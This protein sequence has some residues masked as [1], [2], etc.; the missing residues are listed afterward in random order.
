MRAP[1][2]RVMG[3]VKRRV[4]V[5]SNRAANVIVHRLGLRWFRGGELL[6]LTTVERSSGQERTTPVLYLRDGADWIVVASNGGA[7]REPGWWLNLQAGSPGKV[8]VNGTTTPVTG[9]EIEDPERARVYQRLL[10]E[11]FDY[12]TYQAKVSRRLAVVRLSPVQV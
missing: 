11:V 10:S 4:F 6:M 5:L 3:P 2:L 1:T 12:D 7:D 8:A 9:T